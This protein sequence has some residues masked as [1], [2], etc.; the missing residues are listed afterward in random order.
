MAGK[1][2]MKVIKK[3]DESPRHWQYYKKRDANLTQQECEQKA[4]W[5]KKSCNYQCIE[6]YERTHPNL[7]HEQHIEL[8]NNAIHKKRYNNPMNFEYY[9][10]H[11]SNISK[12]EQIRLWKKYTHS[13]NY[14]CIDFYI[15]KGMDYDEAKNTRETKV[16]ESAKKISKRVSG[17]LNGM[18]SSKTTK[19]QRNSISPRNIEFYK[20]K[21]P[22]LTTEE[23]EQL[24]QQFFTKNKEKIT[25]AIKDTNI[26]YYIN[27]GMSIDEAKQALHDR[28]A[29]FS[30]QK[31]IDKY[32]EI[33]GTKK[34][35]ERQQKWLSNL[36]KNFE[37]NGDGRSYQSSFA[38]E[39]I[40]ICCN[41]IGITVP[42]KEKYIYW[43][44]TKQA[45][46]YD[47]IFKNKIIEFQG[48]YWHCNPKL[49][50]AEFFNKT[51]QM[52]AK[53]IWEYDELKKE[54]ANHYGYDV[55]YVWE[56]EYN[57]DKETTIKTCIK[58]L[59]S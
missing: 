40:R 49:Y 23:Q 2:G 31:C 12:D 56:N 29:T 15:E 47:F 55:L 5:F 14:Q 3:N 44:Q 34:F 9:E 41:N 6:Y 21:Y 26:E 50:D 17:E 4:N 13:H 16:K 57:N 7:S 58:F 10:Y 11:Y 45:F 27:Q 18:H 51:K 46:A 22:D 37:N 24:R 30:L 42:K 54:C 25:N 33:E 48:D 1:S 20:R 36:H 32:G 19:Q 35:C 52:Y 59:T 8:L 53:D 39:I 43:K 28:Q 38:K